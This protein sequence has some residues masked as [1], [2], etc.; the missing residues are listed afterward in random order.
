MCLSLSHHRQKLAAINRSAN[1][2][3]K[4]NTYGPLWHI[5]GDELYRVKQRIASNL[6]ID[7]NSINN[8][9]AF[10][11]LTLHRTKYMIDECHLVVK[12]HMKSTHCLGNYVP[13]VNLICLSLSLT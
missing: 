10:K 11:W 13:Y 3:F 9:E 1:T 8:I 4:E 7:I 5:Q 6:S 12:F 2:I